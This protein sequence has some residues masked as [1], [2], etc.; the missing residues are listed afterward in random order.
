MSLRSKL[1]ILQIAELR[2]SYSR[3]FVGYGHV[4]VLSVRTLRFFLFLLLRGIETNGNRY[5]C[6]KERKHK[7]AHKPHHSTADNQK[8]IKAT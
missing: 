3:D 5:S 1:K 4:E 8:Q 6:K 7:R 2:F